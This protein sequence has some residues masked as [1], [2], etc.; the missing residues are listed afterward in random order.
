MDDAIRT[1]D[2][3][4]FVDPRKFVKCF[5]VENEPIYVPMDELSGEFPV[6]TPNGD[7]RNTGKRH[8][9]LPD[10]CIYYT[11]EDVAEMLGV[12]LSQAYK[13]VKALNVELGK[14]KYIVIAGKIPKAFFHKKYYGLEDMVSGQRG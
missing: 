8:R 7:R 6:D 12:S 10:R 11:A 2:G 3:L 13:V 4:D 5:T 9:E 1:I 14:E